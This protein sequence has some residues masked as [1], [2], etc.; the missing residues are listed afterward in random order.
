M[1]GRLPKFFIESWTYSSALSVVDQCDAWAGPS[2]FDKLTSSNFRAAKG[3][4]M[5]LAA[6]QVVVPGYAVL[7]ELIPLARHHRYLRRPLAV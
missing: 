7:F 5:Q 4:L 2:E 6:N 1:Q 3:E